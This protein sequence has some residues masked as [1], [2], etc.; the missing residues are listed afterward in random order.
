MAYSNFTLTK[1]IADFGLT[2]ETGS[3]LFAHV[4][5]VAPGE[6]TRRAIEE[7]A[8]LALL[9]GNEK[10]RSELIV[11][12]LLAELWRRAERRISVYSGVELTVDPEAGLNGVCDFLI[13]RAPQLP[14]VSP[15]LFVVV[16]AK[17]DDLQAAYGQCAAEM[18]A[19]ARLNKKSNTDVE[20]VFGCV[21][22]GTNWRF[23]KLTGARLDIDLTEYQL[24]QMDRIFG[25][26]CHLVGVPSA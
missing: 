4:A 15:P 16:E 5:A 14:S 9:I 21:T 20:T 13:G 11:A 25:V 10:A 7:N 19:A 17:K 24:T 6:T 8:Q 2:V 1:A 12:P 18:V 3:E 26:L 22:T 23:L